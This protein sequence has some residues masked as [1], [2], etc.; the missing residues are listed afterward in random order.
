MFFRELASVLAPKLSMV[1]RRLL[2]TGL[3]PSQW[4]CADVV[5]SPKGVMSFLLSGF[6]PILI[7]PVLSKVYERLVSSNL[8]AFMEMKDVFL[9]YQHQPIVRDWKLVIPC[10]TKFARDKQPWTGQVN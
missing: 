9:R 8:C 6:W 10:G 5:Q 4:C 3:F 7:M 1:F 2:R